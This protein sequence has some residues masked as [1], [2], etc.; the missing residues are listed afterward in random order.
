MLR[1]MDDLDVGVVAAVLLL[2]L[3]YLAWVLFGGRPTRSAAKAPPPTD[4]D[5]C[6]GPKPS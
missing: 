5:D 6:C 3:A 1:V 4:N 2:A